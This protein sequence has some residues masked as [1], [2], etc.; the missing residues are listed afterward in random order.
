MTR[1]P[2][3]AVSLADAAAALAAA[4]VQDAERR[5]LLAQVLA[6]RGEAQVA[7]A[8]HN[9]SDPDRGSL[10]AAVIDDRPFLLD[11]LL[12]AV[13]R[14]GHTARVV[15]HPVLSALPNT[16]PVAALVIELEARLDP[17]HLEPLE[18][19]AR[20]ALGAPAASWMTSQRANHGF[21]P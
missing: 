7:T 10:L 1:T 21:K 16:Q 5:A 4:G 14:S 18:D 12:V 11:T 6:T 17:E 15:E 20:Q 2:R 3:P 9:T 19:L 8:V 13:R